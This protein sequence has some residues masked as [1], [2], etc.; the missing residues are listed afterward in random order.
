MTGRW[1]YPVDPECPEV[2]K[3]HET[4]VEDPMTSAMGAPVGEFIDAFE[5][6]HRASCTHCQE[7]GAEN[8]DVEYA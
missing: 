5:K 2:Q 6:K 3:H 1:V 4:L 8:A 7:H